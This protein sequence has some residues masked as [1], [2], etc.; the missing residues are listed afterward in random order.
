MNY[1]GDIALGSTIDF[2]FPSRRFS[3]GA[4]FTLAGSPAL[5]AYVGNGT[6]EITAGITLTVDFD[7]R[8][9]LN[10]VRVVATSGNGFAAGTDVDIVITAGTVDSVSVVGEIVGSFSI[11]NRSALRPATAGRTLAVSAAG[12]ADANVT[13][14]AGSAITQS[15]GRQEVNVS[16][17]GGSAGTFASGR[18]EVNTTHAAGTAWGSGAITAASIASGALTSATF[19]AGAFDAVWSVATRLLTAGTNI[20]LAKG[21]GV[22]GFNDLDA[23]GVRTALGMSTNNMDTQLAALAS[24]NT[25]MAAYVDT[26]VGAILTIMQ[27]LDTAL[28]LDGAV[29][30]FTTNALELAPTG[31]TAPTAEEIADEVEA[32]TL[33]ANVAD[34][35]GFSLTSGERTAIANEVEAQII[36]DADSEQVLQAI[37]DKIAGTDLGDLNLTAIAS[38]VW[39][40]AGRT[41]TAGTNIVLA[42]GTGIT[43]FND[44]TAAATASAVRTELATE[45]ARIDTGISTR[46][47]SASYT[48]P[49]SAATIATQVRVELG[50]ELGRID[51]ATSTRLATAGYTAPIAAATIAS[52]VR[53][54]LTTELGRMDA[55]VSTRLA[56]SSYDDAAAVASAVRTELS[57]ELGRMDVAVSTRLATVGYTAA[58]TV[59]EIFGGVWQ[60]TAITEAYAAPGAAFTPAQGVYMIWSLLAEREHA[61]TTLRARKLD[62]TTQSMAFTL[63]D[64]TNPTTQTRTA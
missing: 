31:G 4:P 44:P 60:G 41:L 17:F 32:R 5:A 59:A 48:S 26:E 19:A 9:G 10:H 21:T 38:A 15:G 37:I 8:A 3:S 6:T 11:E 23:A 13:H 18:P 34:K 7:G 36:D 55:A 57:T 30:R 58:P 40:H 35:T 39:A 54:E 24:Q 16:H 53:T 20:V 27:K 47:A 14:N 33:T 46:L 22:T 52:A 29:Y 61:G 50:T 49:P 25:A 45:L 63:D 42:K 2:K 12:G 28:E 64:A 1:R 51:V 62:G 43:G 56:A